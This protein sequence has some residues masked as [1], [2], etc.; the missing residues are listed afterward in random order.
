MLTLEYFN[1]FVKEI[2][3]SNG[4]LHKQAV[5]EKYAD[6][7]SVREY[8]KIAFDP[9]KVYGVSTKKLNKTITRENVCIVLA[10]IFDLFTYLEKHNTGTDRD[11]IKCQR[12]IEH[13]EKN[14]PEC[15]DLLK[16]LICKDLSIGV[17]AKT[18][19]KVI[20]GLIPTF[21]VQLANKYFDKPQFVEGKTFAVT[22]KI[23]GGR[24][25][26]LKE[27]GQVSFYTRAGQKYEGLVD[28][29]DEMMVFM[30]DNICLDGEITLQMRGNLS[31]K[32]AFTAQI[33]YFSRFYKV[34]AIDFVGFGQSPPL[35]LPLTYRP[36]ITLPLSPDWGRAAR[37]SIKLPPRT[38][39]APTNRLERR[40]RAALRSG[41]QPEG[42]L[43]ARNT[44]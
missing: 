36:G 21:D 31:S 26:A 3:K 30:P 22:T 15:V 6:D 19:N 37:S 18:I 24:I 14:A 1:N 11:I 16:A 34:T 20:P 28:L 13:V 17:D 44:T 35:S 7:K 27:N 38:I 29:E 23:D 25:I 40:S 12:Y 2:N 42:L 10:N 41:V 8:L 32:E 33:N 4:R 39:M 5:L 9:Y 43:V